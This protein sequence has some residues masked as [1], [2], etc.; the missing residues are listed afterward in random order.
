[1]KTTYESQQVQPVLMNRMAYEEGLKAWLRDYEF[2]YFFTLTFRSDVS[3]SQAQDV[4]HKFAE[5]LS[6]G[7]F[8]SSWK[9]S[10]DPNFRVSF[11]ASFEKNTSGRLHIHVAMQPLDHSN[12]IHCAA[13][14]KRLVRESWCHFRESGQQLDFQMIN[15]QEDRVISYLFKEVKYDTDSFYDQWFSAQK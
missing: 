3:L 5:R 12:R 15:N 2:K 8:G 7:A 10:G 4:L 14:V 11:V 9:L 1:M 6:K 13:D